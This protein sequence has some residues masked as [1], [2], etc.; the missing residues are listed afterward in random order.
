MPEAPVTVMG[1]PLIAVVVMGYYSSD[2]EGWAEVDQLYWRKRDGSRG[3]AL[4]DAL[5]D[6]V[7][8]QGYEEAIIEQVWDH[9]WY[10]QWVW[11]CAT[12]LAPRLYQGGVRDNETI[13]GFF[14]LY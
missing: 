4:S 2:G 9:L 6:K 3:K 5:Y 11:S 13:D 12:D 7:L 10:W 8:E 1:L 14:T